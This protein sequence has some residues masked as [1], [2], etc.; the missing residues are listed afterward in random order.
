[1]L[2]AAGVAREALTAIAVT[3]GPGQYG[4]LRTGVATAQGLALAL[5]VPLAGGRRLEADALPHLAARR[6]GAHR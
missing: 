5:D 6:T 1:M 4:A 2:A 3:T